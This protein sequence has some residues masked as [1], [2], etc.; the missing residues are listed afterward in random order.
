MHIKCMLWF[1][2]WL[3]RF[4]EESLT[5]WSRVVYDRGDRLR[6]QNIHRLLEVDPRGGGFRRGD[7]NPLDCDLLVVDETSMVDIMLMQA[8]R[9]AVPDKSALHSHLKPS[10]SLRIAAMPRGNRDGRFFS[11]DAWET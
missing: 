4:V 10:R 11:G 9:K 7:D 5:G 2:S 8:L 3:L 6:G 1:E